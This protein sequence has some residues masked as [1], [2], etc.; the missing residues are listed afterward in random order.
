[1]KQVDRIT[2]RGV[3]NADSSAPDAVHESRP[4]AIKKKWI[5]VLLALLMLLGLAA[6]KTDPGQSEGTVAGTSPGTDSTGGEIETDEWG[7]DLIDNGI[8]ENL[9][10]GGA[11]V[12][13]LIRSGEQYRREWTNDK[14]TD[15]LSNEIFNRNEK[16]QT[17]LGVTFNFIPTDEGKSGT[18]I[19]QKIINT[20]KS[21]MGGIDIVSNYAAYAGNPNLLEN[22]INLYDSKLTYLDLEKTYWNQNF[23]SSAEAFGKL[24]VV[25]GDVNLSVFD[26]T[27]ITYF[28]Q[29][30]CEARGITGLYQ[31]VLEGG[32]TYEMLYEYASDV[33]E[34]SGLNDPSKDLYGLTTIKGSE[35][36]DG[37]LYSFDCMLTEAAEDGTH[38]LVTGSQLTKL[39]EAMGKIQTL[40]YS[41]G[42]YM[43]TS[44]QQN[45]DMFTEGR[46]L[47][48]IDVIYHYASG[49]A[50]MRDMR[51]KY[52]LLPVPKYDSS[53]TE[54][55]SGVQ[56]AH[57][58]M[59]V[60]YH[61]KQNYEMV[62]AVLE[63]LCAE[64]YRS[65]RPYYFEKIVKTVY[66]QDSESGQV[67]DLVLAGTRWDI[68]DVYAATAGYVRN[69]V[70]RAVFQNKGEVT[71]AFGEHAQS[72]NGLLADLDEWLMTHY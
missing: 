26:R 14:A 20:G 12:N 7:Q 10:Y 6:C 49:N 40:C 22:Y 33:H 70:W 38:K 23:I 52:G 68:A 61:S 67:F 19:N 4:T 32:W 1:M 2:D 56:D 11:V 62:S 35:A 58:V 71:T 46:A 24:F 34:D 47:F 65:V 39:S 5:S 27:I 60:M 72:L 45:Y 57:N 30:Q 54:Y 50:Q 48:N 37:F 55:Y 31:L 53:Q 16:V 18:T 25:V 59:S 43:H 42:A 13:I 66:L 69:K 29:T 28:N 64:N 21:G 8:P 44:S 51:D 9:D 63:S 3:R 17:D 15:A 41:D 36:S